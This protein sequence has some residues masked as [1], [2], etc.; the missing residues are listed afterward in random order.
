MRLDRAAPAR[1]LRPLLKY[2]A[3]FALAGAAFTGA[4]GTAAAQDSLCS[5]DGDH[6]LTTNPDGTTCGGSETDIDLYI[7]MEPDVQ[8][9][10]IVYNDPTDTARVAEESE[11]MPFTPTNMRYILGVPG[12][13]V[14]QPAYMNYLRFQ[15]DFYTGAFFTGAGTAA[16]YRIQTTHAVGGSR[17]AVVSGRVGGYAGAIAVAIAVGQHTYARDLEK[18]RSDCKRYVD[19]TRTITDDRDCD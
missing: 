12:D 3:C 5:G 18:E 1:K 9:E 17:T 8:Q 2:A 10:L 6:A 14:Y 4:A 11:A 19:S 13:G 7:E 15:V 16:G